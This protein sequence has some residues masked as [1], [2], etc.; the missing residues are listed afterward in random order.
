MQ[1]FKVTWTS[2]LISHIYKTKTIIS[3]VH[4]ETRIML[5]SEF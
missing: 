2:N 4:T 3:K 5:T 1:S